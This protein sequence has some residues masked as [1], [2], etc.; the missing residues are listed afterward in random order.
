[1]GVY[2]VAAICLLIALAMPPLERV[3]L[4]ADG[5]SLALTAFGLALIGHDGLL[6]LLAVT[7]TLATIV[8]VLMS[9]L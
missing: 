1:M 9:L 8:L 2:W 6:A 3:P 5:A 4:S 7:V